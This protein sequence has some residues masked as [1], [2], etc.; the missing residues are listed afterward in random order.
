MNMKAYTP[1]RIIKGASAMDGLSLD[2]SELSALVTDSAALTRL[3]ISLP[4]QAAVKTAMDSLQAS[5]TTGVTGTPEQFLQEFLSG[6][7]HVVTTAR[8][9]DLLA[10]TTTAGQWHDEEVIQQVLEHLGT[11]GMYSD[12]GDSPLA[13]WKTSFDRRTIVRLEMATLVT[14]LEEARAGAVNIN[15]G[16]EKR[17]AAANAMEIFRNEIFFNGY[18]DGANRTYGFLNDPNLPSYVTV[19]TGDAADTE[20]ST[21]SVNERVS[22]IVTAIS[23]LRTQ[24]GSNVDPDRDPLI[25]AVASSVKDFMNDLDETGG[26]G[27]Y[28]ITVNKWLRENYPNIEVIAVPELDEA[29]GGENAF[30]LYADKVAG[31]GTDDGST[32]TQVVPVKFMP[33]GNE[34]KAKGVLEV[35]SN[36]LAGCYVKRGYAV[37]RYSGI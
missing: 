21:K 1:R 19:D 32:M 17:A 22:D 14:K 13:S 29:D 37:V 11:P 36:A 3:G 4:Q 15:S 30:Y 7:V 8:R 6:I 10:S 12:H 34:Q 27:D 5:V 28:G 25:L 26:A 33:V 2:K 23:A 24:S 18:N 35:Y 20:W 9:G 16:A 31:S